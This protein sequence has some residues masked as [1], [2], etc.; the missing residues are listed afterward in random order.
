MEGNAGGEEGVRK[1]S[2]RGEEGVAEEAR[3]VEG[4]RRAGVER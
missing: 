1:R 3:E 4:K 2:G